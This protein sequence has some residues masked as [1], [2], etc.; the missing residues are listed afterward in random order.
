MN[1][2]TKTTSYKSKSRLFLPKEN[3]IVFENQHPAI[4]SR[5]D[6]EKTQEKLKTISKNSFSPSNE[7]K[8][9]TFFRNKCVC[10]KCGA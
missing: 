10:A 1:F 4:I 5:E 8:K 7:M 2:K 6:F 3:W 9:D